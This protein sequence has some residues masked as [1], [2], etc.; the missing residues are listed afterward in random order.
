MTAELGYLRTA[1]IPSSL[2][3]W[4]LILQLVL[5]S[6]V[7]AQDA[8]PASMAPDVL[9]AETRSALEELTGLE[10]KA[11]ADREAFH[12]SVED[13]GKTISDLGKP[14]PELAT[15]LDRPHT[16][17]VELIRGAGLGIAMSNADPRVHAE[18]QRVTGH[19]HEAGVAHAIARL[20]EG[21]W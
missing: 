9:V 20:L 3:L 1:T 2:G 6:P 19:H 16:F 10:A 5:P 4:L 12:R 18:A 17:D 8:A 7:R 14:L 21:A 15:T 13:L 11:L